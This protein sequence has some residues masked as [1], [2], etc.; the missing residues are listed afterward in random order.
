MGLLVKQIIYI[1]NA[2]SLVAFASTSLL[3][4]LIRIGFFYAVE[5]RC[6]QAVSVCSSVLLRVDVGRR[7]SQAALRTCAGLQLLEVLHRRRLIRQHGE[8]RGRIFGE[9]HL[10]MGEPVVAPMGG[11]TETPGTWGDRQRPGP[12]ARMRLM[13][14]LHEA[15]REPES[16]AR[17]R[18][19]LGPLRGARARLGELGSACVVRVSRGTQGQHLLFH[20]GGPLQVGEGADG[21]RDRQGGRRPTCPHQTGLDLV[22]RRPMDDD[23]RN[24]AAQQRLTLRLRQHGRRP[25]GRQRTANSKEGRAY[26]RSACAFRCVRGLPALGRGRLGRLELA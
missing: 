10:A 11:D 6:S 16:A 23:F 9:L 24:E 21:D 1:C 12:M 15:M 3:F 22:P 7:R 13:P 5:S 14:L 18:E 2:R 20:S 26:L 19:D 25:Q 17:A 4:L 8:A